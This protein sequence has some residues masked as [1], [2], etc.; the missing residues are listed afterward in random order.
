M[1]RRTPRVSPRD[2][3]WIRNS[4]L[5]APADTLRGLRPDPEAVA[6]T[7]RFVAERGADAAA[8]GS[9][10]EALLF[11]LGQYR[12]DI[13]PAVRAA[14][15]GDVV[16]SARVA[17]DNVA[18]LEKA[19]DAEGGSRLFVAAAKALSLRDEAAGAFEGGVDPDLLALVGRDR[20]RLAE[21]LEVWLGGLRTILD[22]VVEAHG[23]PAPKPGR[24]AREAEA[25]ALG[26]IA[27]FYVHA[28]GLRP[29]LSTDPDD[30]AMTGDFVDFANLLCSY[31]GAQPFTDHDYKK[32]RERLAG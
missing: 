6:A 30:F 7:V 27:N 16:R 22:D 21:R 9:Q 13:D 1:D 28:T 29:T 12:I 19:L 32:L 26:Q 24:P 20:E 31:V 14:K 11:A 17:L 5:G 18:A 23:G 10:A 2:A 8:I 4:Y 15:V 25:E 3:F